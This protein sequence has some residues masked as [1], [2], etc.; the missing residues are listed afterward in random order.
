MACVASLGP[1]MVSVD[2]MMCPHECGMS[3]MQLNALPF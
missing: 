3:P 2:T 1:A